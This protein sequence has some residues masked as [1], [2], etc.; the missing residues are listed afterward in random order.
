MNKLAEW[1]DEYWTV[2][3]Q[4]GNAS[5]RT[6]S[7][8]LKEIF[9][10]MLKDLIELKNRRSVGEIKNSK[11]VEELKKKLA[12][13]KKEQ[14]NQVTD[15]SIKVQLTEKDNEIDLTRLIIHEK[16]TAYEE[17]VKRLGETSR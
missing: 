1:I 13:A 4:I 6:S 10:K 12:A 16:A 15:E 7:K 11:E 2:N 5:Y 8:A 9:S 3:D 17:L 14:L